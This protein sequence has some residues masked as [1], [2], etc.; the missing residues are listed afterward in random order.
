TAGVKVRVRFP[1]EKLGVTA[2]FVPPAASVTWFALNT[3]IGS[4]NSIMTCALIGTSINPSA[5][6]KRIRSPLFRISPP[7][8]CSIEGGPN[9]CQPKLLFQFRYRSQLRQK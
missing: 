2:M 5:G 3:W 9:L 7:V 8:E 6:L 4:L 1:L